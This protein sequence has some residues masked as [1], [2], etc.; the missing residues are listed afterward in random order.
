MGSWI[1]ERI[2]ECA[3]HS[4]LASHNLAPPLLARFNNGLL[5]RFI[6]GKVCSPADLRRPEVWRGVAR[7]LAE[8]HATLPIS[9]IL[10]KGRRDSLKGPF[11]SMSKIADKPT[12][13][14]WTV[15]YKWTCALP[16]DNVQQRN[17]KATLQKEL[18]WLTE[19]LGDIPGIDSQ[20]LIFGHCDLL[21]GNVIIQP[22][23][24]SPPSGPTELS[25]LSSSASSPTTAPSMAGSDREIPPVKVSFI[26][27][28]YATPSPVA[29][30]I[31]NHFAEWGGFDC[32][33]TVLP[34]RAQRRNFLSTYLQA[35][36]SF[37]GREFKQAELEQ[38]MDEVDLFRGA[39]GFYWGIWALIQAQISQIEFDYANYAEIRL[40]EYYAWKD[41]LE[42][43]KGQ[44]TTTDEIPL[45]ERRWAQEE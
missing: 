41:A 12:P 25:P 37:R 22:I 3:A 2:G 19:Q 10:D 4:L 31:A 13:N 27:Y 23:A 39:P 38:L 43:Q 29:F 33:F 36:N 32:D 20:C 9:A 40:G 34:T 11:E 6:S 16:I 28:E 8:W 1:N 7:R 21:H 42:R 26:D 30:D 17:R 24:Y 35:Y 5:Y 44:N 45:R 18:E 15:M 14:I